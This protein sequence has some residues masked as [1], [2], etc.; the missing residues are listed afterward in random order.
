VP[1]TAARVG[2]QGDL[3][4]AEE[5]HDLRLGAAIGRDLDLALERSDDRVPVRQVAGIVIALPQP[6]TPDFAALIRATS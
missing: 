3:L 2:L 4:R 1:R 5:R 6:L